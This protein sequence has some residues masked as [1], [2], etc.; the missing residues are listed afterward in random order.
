MGQEITPKL[1]QSPILKINTQSQSYYPN[2]DITGLIN[3][4]LSFPLD[5]CDIEIE[6]YSIEGWVY[7][8]V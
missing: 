8:K 2:S 5:L 3:L 1:K 4:N 7:K 6:I